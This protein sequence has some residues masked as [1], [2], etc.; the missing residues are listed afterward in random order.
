MPPNKEIYDSV[1]VGGGIAGL[2][3][4]Y[5]LKDKNVL[6]LEK[7]DRLGGRIYTCRYKD[8]FVELG[9]SFS[10]KEDA[11]PNGHIPDYFVT[12]QE[13]GDILILSEDETIKGKSVAECIT[14]IDWNT[15]EADTIIDFC[16]GNA[17]ASNLSQRPLMILDSIFRQIHLGNIKDYLQD[18]QLEVMR[19]RFPD[20][21]ENG[22]ISIIDEYVAQMKDNVD[23]KTE[24]EVKSIQKIDSHYEIEY[25]LQNNIIKIQTKTLAIATNA[26]D[27]KKILP[28]K[29]E[30]TQQ[31]LNQIKYSRSI[32][33]G[34]ILKNV[35]I[36][37]IRCVVIPNKPLGIIVK[38]KHRNDETCSLICGYVSPYIDKMKSL[39]DQE[40]IDM[41]IKEVSSIAELNIQQDDV[42]KI[43]IKRWDAVGTIISEGFEKSKNDTNF[44]VEEGFCLAGDYLSTE[45]ARGYGT[46]DSALSGKAAADYIIQYLMD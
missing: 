16:N 15:E 29:Y 39:S 34:V 25:I 33:V 44:I 22:N 42:I 3:I 26:I 7:S 38:Q 27:A 1:I 4:A 23:I 8:T 13:R 9:A 35:N 24:A 45:R 12:K 32:M 41:T 31:F 28:L 30:K 20:H 46:I 11:F 19:E 40:I 43:F 18:V 10:L 36:P 21:Y 37:D 5:K 2:N 14:S 17:D 6:L